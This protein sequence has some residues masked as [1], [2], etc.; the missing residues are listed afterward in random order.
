[1]AEIPYG[2]PI[3]TR[4]PRGPRRRAIT[5]WFVAS[6]GLV[7]LAQAGPAQ[8]A[9]VLNI[10]PASGA[11]FIEDTVTLRW[12]LDV[13][14]CDPGK[15]AITQ[16]QVEIDGQLGP[17]YLPEPSGSGLNAGLFAAA[18]SD[19]FRFTIQA[20]NVRTDG[21][22]SVYRW[23]GILDCTGPGIPPDPT[24]VPVHVVG[25]W[26][27]F[28]VTRLNPG[29]SP[30][31]PGMGPGMGPATK[32]PPPRVAPPVGPKRTRI[33]QFLGWAP[34]NRPLPVPFTARQVPRPLTL[35]GGT[36][37]S[38]A[39]GPRGLLLVFRYAGIPK[40]RPIAW[41]WTLDGRRLATGGGSIGGQNLYQ[42]WLGYRNQ[43][44]PNGVYTVSIRLGKRFLGS[45]SV[46][47]AC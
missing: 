24:A 40:A 38:C 42:V 31:G 41:T 15:T 18:A 35:P 12:N 33:R 4:R 5:A 43:S 8:S 34:R 9:A 30:T 36:I 29:T 20:V 47:R 13:S 46:R 17:A 22:P 32:V 14:G 16:V 25:P 10:D 21:A 23:R 19:G 37:R 1:M 27:E 2:P 28:R 44:A 3:P 6:A 45:A 26:S 11:A 7:A 39:R